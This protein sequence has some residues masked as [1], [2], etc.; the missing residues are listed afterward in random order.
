MFILFNDGKAFLD[1]K[2]IDCWLID[3][4]SKDNVCTLSVLQI[5]HNRRVNLKKYDNIDDAKRALETVIRATVKDDLEP[6]AVFDLDAGSFRYME[7]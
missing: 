4:E 2:N 1:T 3:D 5:M 6:G 7:A